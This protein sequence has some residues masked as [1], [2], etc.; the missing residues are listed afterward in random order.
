MIHQKEQTYAADGSGSAYPASRAPVTDLPTKMEQ[1]A[2]S[3]FQELGNPVGGLPLPQDLEFRAPYYTLHGVKNAA[4][5]HD[6]MEER[7]PFHRS[8]ATQL[9]LVADSLA[10]GEGRYH[11]PLRNRDGSIAGYAQFKSV[12]NR[13]TPVL[14]TVLGPEMRPSG[15]NIEGRLKWGSY[16]EVTGINDTI[17]ADT[18]MLDKRPSWTWDSSQ[19]A[20]AR[21]LNQEPQLYTLRQ[22]FD[23]VGRISGPIMDSAQG[24]Q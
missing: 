4:H 21:K 7:T 11:I 23:S 10:L 2:G 9:Q 18:D 6:R 17:R 14:A 13:A 1:D 15:E 20:P 16:Q 3:A 8:Y 19:I 12:P 24:A 22:A 5:A